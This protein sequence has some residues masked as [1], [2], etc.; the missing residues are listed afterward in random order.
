MKVKLFNFLLV[1]ALMNLMSSCKIKRYVNDNFPKLSTIDQQINAINQNSKFLDS[2][3]SSVAVHVSEQMLQKFIPQ[4]LKK[5][6]EEYNE[7]DVIIHKFNPVIS[8]KQQSIGIQSSFEITLPDLKVKI[9]G[10]LDGVTALSTENDSL[11]LRSAFKSLRITNL[12]F[13]KKP[14]LKK[15]AIAKAITLVL[16]NF[17]QRVNGKYLKKPSVIHIG[18]NST[19]TFDPKEMLENENT[20]AI[21]MRSDVSRYVKQ[22][23][24]LVDKSGISILFD[25]DSKDSKPIESALVISNNNLKSELKKKFNIYQNRYNQVWK[26]NFSD[27]DNSVSLAVMLK[28]KE[29]ASIFNEALINGFELKQKIVIPKN[30]FNEMV[31]LKRSRVN[32]EKVRKKFKFPSFNGSSCSWSCRVNTPLGSFDDPVCLANRAACRV[33]RETARIAWQGSRETARIAHQIKDE[34]AVAACK[35]IKEANNFVKI[36]RFK[37]EA[38]GS[39]NGSVMFKNFKFNE[40]LSSISFN[41]SGVVNLDILTELK[42]QPQNLGY[43]FLCM[44]EYKN[45]SKSIAKAIFPNQNLTISVTTSKKNNDLELLMDFPK[46]NYEASIKPSPIQNYLSDGNL[47]LRCPFFYSLLSTASIGTTIG[48]F[49]NLIKLSES[50]KLILYGKTKSDYKISSIKQVFKPMVFIL[51]NNEKIESQINWSQK[52]IDFVSYKK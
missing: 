29:I 5:V 19:L 52:S 16:K 28:K 26:N 37:G 1:V 46:I 24:I 2:I 9:K 43:I 22:S 6:S 3:E 21:G 7:N 20:Q 23:S 36:G 49:I 27:I 32:C 44:A 33:T 4:E 25:L 14:S 50:D 11:Y 39:G 18:W 30:S 47:A 31:E 15:R 12:D 17:I 34:A 8:F 35:V 40:D 10:K 42:L 41:T 38:S 13:D 51:N 48:D 45:N